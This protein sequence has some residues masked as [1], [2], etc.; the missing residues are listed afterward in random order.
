MAAGQGGQGETEGIGP[1][2]SKSKGSVTLHL[3]LCSENFYWVTVLQISKCF[4][5]FNNILISNQVTSEHHQVACS[6]AYM[7]AVNDKAK[8]KTKR[9]RAYD[10][11][12][13]LGC[14]DY[15]VMAG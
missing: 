13:S 14:Q 9:M 5:N 15:H 7:N 2:Q 3:S 1:L 12:N 8:W 6:Q 11:D 4:F 10:C